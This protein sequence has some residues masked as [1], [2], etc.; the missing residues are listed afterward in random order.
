[1]YNVITY[2]FSPPRI[3]NIQNCPI[4]NCSPDHDFNVKEGGFDTTGGWVER[5]HILLDW[6]QVGRLLSLLC[7]GQAI[8]VG[9]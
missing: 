1:M 4:R 3:H 9:R 7:A 6:R 5:I 8:D 2:N